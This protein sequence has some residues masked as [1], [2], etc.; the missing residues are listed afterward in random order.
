MKSIN[1][2]DE[3]N[4]S[5]SSI[6]EYFYLIS[7]QNTNE[8]KRLSAINSCTKIINTSSNNI[9]TTEEFLFW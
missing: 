7:N 8:K 5:G 9:F 2:Y 4:G 3:F 1:N 6:I